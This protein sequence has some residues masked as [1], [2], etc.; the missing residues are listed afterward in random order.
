MSKPKRPRTIR[1]AAAAAAL[2]LPMPPELPAAAHPNRGLLAAVAGAVVLA[3]A[4]YAGSRGGPDSRAAAGRE[5]Q[6][7]VGDGI[8]GAAR[9]WCACRGVSS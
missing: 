7:V 3:A 4:G 2:V 1:R 6:V 8:S 9:P 5:V